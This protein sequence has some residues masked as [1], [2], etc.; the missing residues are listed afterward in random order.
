MIPFSPPYIDDDIINEVSQ[1]LKSGWI[2]T[3][4]KTKQF[5]KELSDYC[6]VE[7]VLCVNSGT[8]GLELILRWFGISKGDE[9]ILPAY[10][11]NATAFAIIHCGATPVFVDIKDDFNIDTEEVKS[12]ITSKTK[13]IIPVDIG[14]WPC[15]YDELLEIVKELDNNGKFN[16]TSEIQQKLGRILILSDAAHSFGALYKGEK[17]GKLADITV[18]SFHAV[19]NLTTSEGGAISFNLP[20]PFDNILEY[21]RLS[22][23]TLHGQTKDALT[24][25]NF[26]NWRY[27]IVEEGYKINMPDVLAAIG[28]IQLRK[29]DSTILPKRKKIFEKYR[30]VLKENSWALLPKMKDDIKESS[31]HIFALRIKHID[32]NE[33]N[34]IIEKISEKEISVNVHFIPLPMFTYFKNAGYNI[35]DYPNSYKH[36]SNEISLPVFHELTNQ[37]VDIVS[38]ALKQVVQ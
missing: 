28:L 12:K 13:A 3:G 16:P 38:Q 26:G 14:G 19:K 30:E 37:Q 5:E 6:N 18:F 31:Y 36:Y 9:V 8:S 2:T 23:L 35:E 15:D 20:V 11:Y 7:R 24:K 4:P 29:Y 17:A 1:T 33:R 27:D 21:K 22:I 10:T 32:E 25:I 34:I